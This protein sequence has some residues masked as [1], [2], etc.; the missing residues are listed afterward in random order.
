MTDWGCQDDSF[1]RNNGGG[2]SVTVQRPHQQ[3]D[4]LAITSVD[5]ETAEIAP[6]ILHY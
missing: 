2:I 5:K 4:V 3:C 6:L 1:Y